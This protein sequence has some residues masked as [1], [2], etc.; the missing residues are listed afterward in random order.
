MPEELRQ[1]DAVLQTPAGR[2]GSDPSLL[3]TPLAGHST[4][5]RTSFSALRPQLED[6]NRATGVAGVHAAVAAEL[7]AFAEQHHG[8]LWAYAQEIT[9][10]S[11]IRLATLQDSDT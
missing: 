1:I 6:L 9:M 2:V 5:Q 4:D 11:A 7:E 8:D 10:A 3:S